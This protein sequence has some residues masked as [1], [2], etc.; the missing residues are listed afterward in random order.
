MELKLSGKDYKVIEKDVRALSAKLA[1]MKI[2]EQNG[3]DDT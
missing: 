2:E 3:I 1:A